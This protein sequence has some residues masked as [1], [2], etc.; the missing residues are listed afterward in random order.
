MLDDL[1]LLDMHEQATVVL[2]KQ[3]FAVIPRGLRRA[4]GTGSVSVTDPA[5]GVVAI[6]VARQSG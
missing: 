4:S 6:S 3:N 5:D 1:K 2:Q